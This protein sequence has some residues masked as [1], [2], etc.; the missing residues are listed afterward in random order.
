MTS[1][2]ANPCLLSVMIRKDSIDDVEHDDHGH[3]RWM[4]VVDHRLIVRGQ[5]EPGV[6]AKVCSIGFPFGDQGT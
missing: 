4:D 1:Q 5:K 3:G 6:K 2:V